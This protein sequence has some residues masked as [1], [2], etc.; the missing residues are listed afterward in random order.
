MG[1]PNSFVIPPAATGLQMVADIVTIVLTLRHTQS[2]VHRNSLLSTQFSGGSGRHGG[3]RFAISTFLVQDG[4]FLIAIS[5]MVTMAQSVVLL[6][7]DI[8]HLYTLNWMVSCV[9][10]CHWILQIRQVDGTNHD[11]SLGATTSVHFTHGWIGNI[12]APLRLFG[13]DT[14]DSIEDDSIMYH[15]IPLSDTVSSEPAENSNQQ[16]LLK[17]RCSVIDIRVLF[18]DEEYGQQLLGI[19]RRG[20]SEPERHADVLPL[21]S[22]VDELESDD[23]DFMNGNS[24]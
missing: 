14:L 2:S 11:S 21:I 7:T 8:D 6:I 12:G 5:L 16:N 23:D 4:T 17:R 19:V 10:H 3:R 15:N 9:L 1:Y 18:E 24:Y 20:S 22:E 13:S